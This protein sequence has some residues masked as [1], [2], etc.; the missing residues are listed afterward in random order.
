MGGQKRMPSFVAV[1]ALGLASA[2]PGKVF[3]TGC[4]APW[5]PDRITAGCRVPEVAPAPESV[6]RIGND[7]DQIDG[8]EP[9]TGQESSCVLQYQFTYDPADPNSNPAINGSGRRQDMVGLFCNGIPVQ[10]R[11]VDA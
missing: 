4:N 6:V 2:V 10:Y 11:W 7:D 1:W 9:G 5:S 3:P 8:S